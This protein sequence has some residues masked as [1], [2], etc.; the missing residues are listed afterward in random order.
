VGVHVLH[1]DAR[2]SQSAAR[3]TALSAGV[4]LALLAITAG[5]AGANGG[6]PEGDEPYALD[7]AG[8]TT[9]IDNPYWPM[10]PGST[11]VYRETEADGTA[12]VRVTVTRS[13]TRIAGIRARIVHDRVVRRGRTVEDTYDW[14]AQDR[15]GNIWYLGED[16]REYDHGRVSTKGSWR[17]GVDGALAG[18]AVPGRPVPGLRYREEFRAG[19]AQDAG[20]VLSVDEQ[21]KVPFGHFGHALLTRD[22]TPLEPRVLEYKLYA[23][24]VGPVLSLSVS[25]GGGREELVRFRRGG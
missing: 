10:R 14:Y 2:H 15:A 6:L 17:A 9:R 5:T 11:W 12:H 22:T 1:A 21:V 19:V 16:T 24:G 7:P 18:V 4:A 25:G 8:F 13:T 20:R 23:K 3:L